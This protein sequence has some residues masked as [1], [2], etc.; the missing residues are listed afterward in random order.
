MENLE[1]TKYKVLKIFFTGPEVF[2]DLYITTYA[3]V[4]VSH[5]D[6]C[7]KRC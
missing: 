6:T 3:R 1:F 5:N 7:T 2:S 4:L